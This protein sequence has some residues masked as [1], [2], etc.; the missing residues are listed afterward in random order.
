MGWPRE[1][2]RRWPR[3]AAERPDARHGATAGQSICISAGSREQCLIQQDECV[4][5]RQQQYA[6]LER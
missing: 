4:K 2:F 1:R 6:L 5:Q 3:P